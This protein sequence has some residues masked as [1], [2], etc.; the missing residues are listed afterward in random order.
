MKRGKPELSVRW[1]KRERALLYDGTGPTGGMLSYY[2][3]GMKWPD[4]KHMAA[5]L[6]SRGY[7]LTTL[8]FSIRKKVAP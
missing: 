5:E 7:D 3:E 8:R 6:E 4:D 2:F 1:S